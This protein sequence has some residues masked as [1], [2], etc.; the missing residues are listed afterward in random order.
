[1]RGTW[2]DTGA[3]L[4]MT[5]PAVVAYRA[6][7]GDEVRRMRAEM[8]VK[9]IGALE[10]SRCCHFRMNRET[11]MGAMIGRD[12]ARYDQLRTVSIL[13]FEPRSNSISRRKI[14]HECILKS[15]RVRQAC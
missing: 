10:L 15:V 6:V 1:M 2:K 14:R 4:E 12:G 13:M 11:S 7:T 5:G 8:A 9:R 3:K